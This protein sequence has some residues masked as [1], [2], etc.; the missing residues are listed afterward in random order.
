MCPPVRRGMSESSEGLVTGG[1]GTGLG[2]S[3][4]GKNEF[5]RTTETGENP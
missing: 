1:G 4:L 2:M 3:K 5:K